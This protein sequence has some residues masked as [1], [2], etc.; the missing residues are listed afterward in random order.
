MEKMPYWYVVVITSTMYQASQIFIIK[1][2]N[3]KNYEYRQNYRNC[4]KQWLDSHH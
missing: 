2:I 4:G 3:N 1:S